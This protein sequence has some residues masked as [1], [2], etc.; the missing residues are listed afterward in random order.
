MRQI[1]IEMNSKFRKAFKINK[2]KM[3]FKGGAGSGKSYAVTQEVL[4]RVST[5]PR[6]NA[7]LLRKV[8]ATVKK[9]T[10]ALAE[11]IMNDTGLR[12]Q[13]TL[14]KSDLTA[15]HN[16]SQN[17]IYFMGLDDREKVKSITTKN[18]LIE[19]IV[20]EE[21]TEFQEED[22]DQLNLRLRGK[23]DYNK[24]IFGMFNPIDELHWVKPKFFDEPD[25]D[26]FT[27]TSTY[28]DNKGVDKEYARVL[29]G[30]KYTNPVFYQVYC[31]GDWGVISESDTIIPYHLAYKATKA[32]VSDEGILFIGVDV[33]EFGDDKSVFY[34]RKGL[35]SLEMEKHEK[36]D[37]NILAEK[38][39]SFML[40]HKSPKQPVVFNIDAGGGGGGL[41]SALEPLVKKFKNVKI[42]RMMF[43]SDG[44]RKDEFKYLATEM[45][46]NLAEK[47]KDISLVDD[48][49]LIPQLC[50]RRYSVEFKTGQRKIEPKKD[51]VKRIQIKSP[52]EADACVLAFMN[53]T[54]NTTQDFYKNLRNN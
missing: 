24:Q 17:T 25:E 32:D 30:Y 20:M 36:L 27:M 28:H 53:D 34:A 13:F 49:K 48:A 45:Y 50:K 21:L 40:R 9:S 54:N 23:S 19:L 18:G 37:Y 15:T 22:F 47:I 3:I 14:N 33:A 38:A 43:G 26:T 41:V 31:L 7:V 44:E 42:N 16:L 10:F 35:K 2:R 6:Y 11:Q 5:R 39:F 8:G 52:D 46:F 29:E 12:D 1:K 51:F 4:I